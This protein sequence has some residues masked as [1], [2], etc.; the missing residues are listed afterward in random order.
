MYIEMRMMSAFQ[1]LANAS[2]EAAFA[3]WL[4]HWI[5]CV[6]MPRSWICCPCWLHSRRPHT[7]SRPLTATGVPLGPAG[8][9]SAEPPPPPE[10]PP[11][12]PPLPSPVSPLPS[13]GEDGAVVLTDGV[14][15]F[16]VMSIRS[17]G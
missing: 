7:A 10:P 9:G 12:P 3:H 11:E 14:G 1:S 13:S 17:H 5:P 16:V 2:S 15:G 8:G 6:D 4:Y